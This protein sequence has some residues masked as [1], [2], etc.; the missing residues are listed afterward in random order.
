M[1]SFP[2][3]SSVGSLEDRKEPITEDEKHVQ[4]EEASETSSLVIVNYP[5][6]IK[7]PALLCVLMFTIG[8]N[9]ATAALSPLKSTLKTELKINNA[10]YGVI[11][12]ANA[13]VN[14]IL[15]VIGGI[16]IDWFGPEWGSMLSS[17]A[18]LLGTLVSGIGASRSSYKALITGNVILGLGSNTIESCQSKLYTHWFY[19]NNLGFVYGVDIAFGRVINTISKATSIPIAE[20]TGWWGWSLWASIPLFWHIPCIMAAVTLLINIAYIFF[21]RRLPKES[22]FVSGKE[23]AKRKAHGNQE[24]AKKISFA[25]I[26]SVP[27]AF[28][29]ITISQLLQSGD[30]SAYTAIQADVITQTRGSSRLVAGYTSSISQ[31]IPIFVTPMIGALFDRYGRRMYYVSATAALWILVYALMG[32]THVHPMVPA[33]LASV[34]LSFNAIPFIAAIPLLAP[35][36]TYL[37]T[38]FGIWKGINWFRLISAFNSAAAVI[39]DVSTGAIQDKTP[40]G[41]HT[42][43]KVM[44]FLI[45]LKSVDVFYGMLYHILDGRYFGG[46]L[47]MSEAEKLRDVQRQE[48]EGS[49]GAREYPLK[50]PVRLWTVLGLGVMFALVVTAWVLYLVYAQGS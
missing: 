48:Q 11:A 35:S 21:E 16:A 2:R 31:I 4:L 28:W 27:A 50:R 12:S 5:W 24:A 32:F 34:A 6:R 43:N 13:L 19:G 36:Q 46:V 40:T 29:I 41:P 44:Y 45:A 20:G 42:Y 1:A 25:A 3:A 26:V 15:P 33:I 9:W 39:M 47:R 8:S 49:A 37:G 22:R 18:V 30:V 38:A 7:G 10:Q 14:T 17:V 23:A